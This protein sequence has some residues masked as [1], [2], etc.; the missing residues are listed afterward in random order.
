MDINKPY[1]L[2]PKPEG[3]NYLH[4]GLP[5]ALITKSRREKSGQPCRIIQVEDHWE[6]WDITYI[7]EEN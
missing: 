1:I 2:K 3:S 5:G 6:V 4:F 7:K